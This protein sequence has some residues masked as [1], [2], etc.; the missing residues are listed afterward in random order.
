MCNQHRGSLSFCG[1]WRILKFCPKND[2]PESASDAKS[3]LVICEMVL[4]VVF[5]E[6]LVEGREA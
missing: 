1:L 5:L 4:Q 6:F 2:I 3:V